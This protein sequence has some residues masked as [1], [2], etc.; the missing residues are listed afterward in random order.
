VLRR[1]EKR[2]SELRGRKKPEDNQKLSM[3]LF[4]EAFLGE[5]LEWKECLGSLKFLVSHRFL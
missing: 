4:Q 2:I 1:L 3:A 5:C